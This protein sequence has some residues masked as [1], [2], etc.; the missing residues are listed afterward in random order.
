[1]KGRG[2]EDIILTLEGAAVR[3]QPAPWNIRP[4]WSQQY[5]LPDGRYVTGTIA[6][7][8]RRE[9]AH[10]IVHQWWKLEEASRYENQTP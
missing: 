8:M 2:V 3:V 10:A 7:A 5:K 6:R 4:Y 9:Y 1:M